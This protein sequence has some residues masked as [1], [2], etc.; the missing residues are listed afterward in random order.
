MSIF[1]DKVLMITSGTSSFGNAILRWFLQ[2]NILDFRIFSRDEENRMTCD[3]STR[4][5]ILRW[6]IRSNSTLTTCAH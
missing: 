5:T 6:L 3:V 4:F 2:T 1:N